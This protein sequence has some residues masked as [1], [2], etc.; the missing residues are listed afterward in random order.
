[1]RY[2]ACIIFGLALVPSKV[3]ANVCK[4]KGSPDKWV[5]SYCQI[6]HN[7]QDANSELSTKCLRQQKMLPRI[8]GCEGN[9]RYKEK[10][11]ELLVSRELYSGNAVSCLED[12]FDKLDYL[13]NTKL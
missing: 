13:P 7:Q 6:K 4:V 10:I 5:E 1:M 12:E 9:L 8:A 2:V 11:C 3:I